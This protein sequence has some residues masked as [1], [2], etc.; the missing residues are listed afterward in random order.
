MKHVRLRADL[1]YIMDHW[2]GE[3]V[4]V[5]VCVCVCLG[6]EAL[7]KKRVKLAASVGERQFTIGLRKLY[8]SWP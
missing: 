3:C 5:C 7:S 1:G 2:L 4:S 6:G 8:N